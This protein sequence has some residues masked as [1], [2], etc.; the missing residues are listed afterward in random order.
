VADLTPEERIAELEAMVSGL[1]DALLT[2]S[3]RALALHR[4]LATKGVLDFDEV[5]G[6]M[7]HMT[8]DVEEELELSPKYQAFREW[9]RARSGEEP[10]P[11]DMKR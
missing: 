3:A 8:A 4:L 6:L 10:P 7:Q 5:K 2:T 11:D 9:R 1:A